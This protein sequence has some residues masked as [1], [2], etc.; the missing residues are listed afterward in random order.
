MSQS[1]FGEAN[2]EM[3]LHQDLKIWELPKNVA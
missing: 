1:R 3:A 2:G